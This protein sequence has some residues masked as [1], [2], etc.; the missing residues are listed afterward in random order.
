MP[1]LPLRLLLRQVRRAQKTF[2]FLQSYNSITSPLTSPFKNSNNLIPTSPGIPELHS[3]NDTHHTL[4][5][6]FQKIKTENIE[7]TQ[8]IF[9]RQETQFTISIDFIHFDEKKGKH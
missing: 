9:T 4:Q 8:I 2:I 3:K 1:D 6:V 5:I 7:K